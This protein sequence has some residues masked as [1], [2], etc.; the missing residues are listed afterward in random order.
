MA[1]RGPKEAQR[2]FRSFVVSHTNVPR[3]SRGRTMQSP[4]AGSPEFRRL[5]NRESGTDL[6]GL[7]WIAR[8]FYPNLDFAHYEG[9]VRGLAARVR[10]RCREPDKPRSTLG[11]INWVL[12]VEEGFQGDSESYFDP[13]NSYLNDVIDRKR[14][15]PIS[16]SVLY[17]PWRG[18]AWSSRASICRPTSC[19]GSASA[20]RPCSSIPSMPAHCSTPDRLRG[21]DHAGARPADHALRD[22]VGSMQPGASRR[23][24]APQPKA[25]S[26]FRA[27]ITR[28]SSPFSAASRP[29]ARTCPKNSAISGCS[30]YA[31]TGPRKPSHRC[32]PISMPH[33]TQRNGESLRALLREARR[34]VALELSAC[35]PRRYGPPTTTASGRRRILACYPNPRASRQS[36]SIS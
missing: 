12:F 15:I 1:S 23:P 7:R 28:P 19:F 16:L 4:F 10:E 18:L 14:G 17:W 26:T 35:P 2:A 30:A 6:S 36:P 24:T 29:C 20:T 32:K 3:S 21:A 31:W 11:L 34:T 33:R 25:R 22:A 5:L 9:V 13:R 8:D 27:T